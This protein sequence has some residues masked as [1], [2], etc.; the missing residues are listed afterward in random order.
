MTLTIDIEPETQ[1]VLESKA[2]LLGV[3]VERYIVGV[4][5]RDASDETQQKQPA[6]P[7]SFLKLLDEA[8]PIIASGLL[9]P[10]SSDDVNSVIDEARNREP[11]NE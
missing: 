2:A 4:L 8:Q 7:T 1:R 5:H 3:P 9:K 6:K 10:L 11:S